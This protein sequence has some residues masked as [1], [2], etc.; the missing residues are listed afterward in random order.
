MYR[1]QQK[2]DEPADS[3]LARMDVTWTEMLTKKFNL[4][5]LQAYLTLRNSR[6]G[7]E[8]QK[9]AVVESGMESG[10]TLEMK[11][12]TA[13]IRMLGSNFFQ[14]MTGQKR[15]KTMKVYDHLT[16]AADEYDE[17]EYESY[18][19]IDENL[20]ED[21]LEALAAEQDDDAT[22]VLQFESAASDM[23]Q[24]DQELSAHFSTYQDARRD[25]AETAKHHLI[26]S[27]N[28]KIPGGR[29]VPSEILLEIEF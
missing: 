25:T 29:N 23:V 27:R 9:R 21:T 10:G 3:Y 2:A 22:M 4:A 26:I 19:G 24:N 11:K 28:T 16:L 6:L 1:I 18:V 13:A 17:T 15:D 8:D 20:D 12:M 7:S 5:E 14:E